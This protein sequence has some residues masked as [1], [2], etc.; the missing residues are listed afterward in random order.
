MSK[1]KLNKKE[2]PLKQKK[3]W[4]VVVYMWALGIGLLGYLVFGEGM[5]QTRPHPIH[6]LAGA[7]GAVVGIGA[8]WLWYRW[9]GDII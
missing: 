5:F 6:W 4:P 9:R 8:G 3:E 2:Q 7:I 1:K